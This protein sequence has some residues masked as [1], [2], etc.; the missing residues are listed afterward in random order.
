[1]MSLQMSANIFY[2]HK[3]IAGFQGLL[4][5]YVIQFESKGLREGLGTNR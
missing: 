1:M 2:L 5:Y 3:S 4:E